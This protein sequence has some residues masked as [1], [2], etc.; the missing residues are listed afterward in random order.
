M[1]CVHCA[2]GDALTLREGERIPLAKLFALLDDVQHLETLSI[3]GGEPSYD[4]ASVTNYILPILKYARARGV[5]TQINSNLTLP[6]ERYEQ[7]VPWL[8]VMHIS[9]NYRD[10][11]DFWEIGFAN[12]AHHTSLKQAEKMFDQMIENTKQLS[13]AGLYVSAETM[14]NYRTHEHLVEMHNAVVELGCQRHEVHPMYPSAFA[15]KLPM[16]SLDQMRQAII[17]LLEGRNPSIWMLFGT[18]PF[19]ACS[20]NE[21]D[22]DIWWRLQSEEKI[23]VRNDPD[24]RNRLNVDTFSGQVSI[25]DFA[26]LTKIASIFDAPKGLDGIFAEWKQHD[27]YD[28]LNCYCDAANC[29][30]PNLLVSNMYYAD[31]DFKKRKA[32]PRL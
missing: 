26:E 22:R 28:R 13:K 7:L 17:R 23:T 2:V 4:A 18:L 19:F 3:T 21:A 12:Q 10:A 14:V 15:E 32:M 6:F 25:T 16:L 11:S 8:D 24:G 5:R 27:M 30:G 20:S 31:V 29:C 1:R 9:Y